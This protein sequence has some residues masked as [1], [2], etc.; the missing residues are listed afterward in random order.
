MLV[1]MGVDEYQKRGMGGLIF[2]GKGRVIHEK[3]KRNL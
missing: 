1:L 2:P 3:G